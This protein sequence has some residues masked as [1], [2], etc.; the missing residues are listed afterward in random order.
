[1]AKNKN[2]DSQENKDIN[3]PDTPDN[4]QNTDNQQNADAPENTDAQENNDAPENEKPQK[5]GKPK[6]TDAEIEFE[7]K[8]EKLF[9]NYPD[10]TKM[11]FTSDGQAF[12]EKQHAQLHAESLED[13]SV[14]T[15]ERKGK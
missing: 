12:L 9:K 4:Q 2:N 1:M 7:K 6:K 11:H 14:T 15:I 5:K 10:K 8:A 3:N 13:S